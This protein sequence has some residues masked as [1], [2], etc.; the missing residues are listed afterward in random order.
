MSRP[1]DTNARPNAKKH[2]LTVFFQPVIK[3]VFAKKVKRTPLF[4]R[5][6]ES[7]PT[8]ARDTDSQRA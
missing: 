8:E 7:R 1:S 4:R 2:D 6:G 5:M 3:E